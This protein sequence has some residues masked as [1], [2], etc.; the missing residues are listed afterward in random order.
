MIRKRGNAMERYD[1]FYHYNRNYGCRLS[2]VIWR[3]FRTLV[4]ENEKLRVSVLLD[5]G[6]DIV[7]LLYKPMDIDFMWRSPAVIEAAGK[8]PFT[9]EGAAGA[10]LDVYEGGWQELLPSISAPTNYKGMGLGFHGELLFLP[11]DFQIV[12]DTPYEV[13]VKLFVRM[14]RAPLLVTK[15]LALRTGSSVLEFEETVENEGDEEFKFM[16]GHHPAIGKPFLDENCVIDLPPGAVGEAYQ[17]DFSGNSPFEPGAE[18]VWPL[19]K[20]KQGKTV[21]LS[22]VMPPEKK[23]AFNT[24]IKN[25]KEGWYGITNLKKRVGFGM[26]WDI[27]VFKYML[28]WAVYRGFYNFPFYGR[29]YNIALE[30]YSAI[31][32]SLDEAIRLNRAFTLAPGGKMSTK[33]SAIVYEAG[34]RIGGF[35]GGGAPIEV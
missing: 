32:D 3:G 20:D 13:K 34:R 30:L 25:L 5:K 19:A 21:D 22:R 35:T 6:T 17:V 24:Y 33:L 31:P 2:E 1:N 8:N 28:I 15:H 18:F 14:R 7:E 26:R 23:T 29:T 11:W 27:G 10:M 12:T 9:K 4:L 16:W